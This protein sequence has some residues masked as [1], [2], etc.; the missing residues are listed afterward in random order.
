M[1]DVAFTTFMSIIPFVKTKY[2]KTTSNLD[3]KN[4]ILFVPLCPYI[5]QY[6][7]KYFK[8]KFFKYKYLAL[9]TNNWRTK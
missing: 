7:I 4:G 3:F 2:S 5:K 8:G 9:K 6:K 1:A